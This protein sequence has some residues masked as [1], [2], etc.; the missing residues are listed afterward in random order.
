MA[1]RIIVTREVIEDLELRAIGRR[2]DY[3]QVVNMDRRRVQREFRR[4]RRRQLRRGLRP[5]A[6]WWVL[7]WKLARVYGIRA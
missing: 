3:N 1:R 4:V 6:G 7:F 5:Q 2:E